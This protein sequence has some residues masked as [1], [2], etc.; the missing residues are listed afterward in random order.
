M[1]FKDYKGMNEVYN[2]YF[3]AYTGPTRT[4]IAVKRLPHP[5]LLIEIQ[6]IG[7]KPEKAKGK[8]KE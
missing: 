5:N 2:Q 3:D 7:V 8:G 4:T 1:D 6:S